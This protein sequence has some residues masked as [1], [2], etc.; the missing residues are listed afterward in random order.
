MKTAFLTG[1]SGFVGAYL[2]KLLIQNGYK[3]RAL[4]RAN[5]NLILTE[6]F[7]NQVEWIKGDLN[8]FDLLDDV[9]QGVDEI[10]HAAALVSF[11]PKDAA[12]MLITNSEGTANLVNA[13]LNTQ[14]KKFLHVSSIAALGRKKHQNH[15]TETAQWENNPL[16]T[17]YAISKFK[18]ECEVWR[19]IQEGLNAVI[20]NPSMILGAGFWQQGTGQFFHLIA[21]KMYFYPQ[22]A[23]GFVDVRDV[24]QAS[25]ALMQSEVSAQRFILSPHN[26]AYKNLFGEIANALNTKPPTRVL[27]AWLGDLAWRFDYLKS[28][29]F[30]KNPTLSRELVQTT[31]NSYTYSSDAIIKAID[32]QFRPFSQTINDTAQAY[33]QSK[34][35]NTA[36]AMLDF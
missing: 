17:N 1:A 26:V 13:A 33:L 20:V 25:F 9:L 31:S 6:P 7:H 23:T 15:Y 34:K 2:L 10:Y 22:G 35:L 30:G 21:K 8:N 14:V 32:Y 24:A 29:I 19:G 11:L 5:S 4:H 3:V 18:A 16:N 28:K 12:Q 36:Y 27:P